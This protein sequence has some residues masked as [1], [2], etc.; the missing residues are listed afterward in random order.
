MK[1]RLSDQ[2][3]TII[4]QLGLSLFNANNV[5]IFGSRADENL[6]GGDIDI[7]LETDKE[8]TLKEKIIFLREFDK[9]FGEQKVDLVI[10]NH[11]DE[12]AIFEIAKKEGIRL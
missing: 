12:Q 6:K 11:Q 7:Y 10:N 5:W 9:A 3:I 4:K 1:P 2:Q 8:Q